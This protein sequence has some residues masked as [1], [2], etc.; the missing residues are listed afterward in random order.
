MSCPVRDDANFYVRYVAF[1]ILLAI[2][3][4][5]LGHCLRKLIQAVKSNNKLVI[6]LF[7]INCL[8]FSTR[9]A[10]WLDI[11]FD[12]PLEVFIFLDHWP[13]IIQSTATLTLGVSWLIICYDYQTHFSGGFAWVIQAAAAVGVV[14]NVGFIAL[15]FGVYEAQGCYSAE[16]STRICII[17]MMPLVGV[18]ACYYGLKLIRLINSSL[19]ESSTTKIKLMIVLA[20]ICTAVRVFINLFYIFDTAAI[21]ELFD[22]EEGALYSVFLVVDYCF[23]EVLFMYGITRTL[24]S[25][26]VD[27]TSS[28]DISLNLADPMLDE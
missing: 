1:P 15:F 4:V 7:S 13:N 20:A 24:T 22:F 25:T 5:A 26:S 6:C 19:I 28:G 21:I 17:A 3:S 23:S 16:V 18:F 14:C 12:Y 9:C 11:A 8:L 27:N 2:Y 10:Y